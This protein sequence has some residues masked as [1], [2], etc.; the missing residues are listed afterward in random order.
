MTRTITTALSLLGAITLVGLSTAIGAEELWVIK[1]GVLNKEALT[2]EATKVTETHVGCGGET[3][4][5]LYVVTP[6]V[7]G[8]Q[9]L[10]RFMTAKSALGDCEFKVVFSASGGGQMRHLA[11]PYISI[12]DR[13]RLC[14]WKTGSP[15][16]LSSARTARPLKGFHAPVE[17]NGFDGNLQSMAV[18]RIG[19]KISCY[20]EGKK[21]NEQPIDPDVNLY[22]WFDAL[23]VSC[24][25]KSIKLTAEK[26]SDHLKTQFKS[27]GPITL[28]FDGT[29]RNLPKPGYGKATRYRLPSLA[30]SKKGTILAFGEARRVTG[31]DI[32]DIDAVVKRSE[33][34]GKTWSPEIVIW[35]AQ[36]L[37]V[38]N[39]TPVVDS[40]SGRIWVMMGRFGPGGTMPVNHFVSYSDDD[41]KTWS[42]PRDI[43]LRTKSPAGTDPTLPGPGGGIVLERGKHAGRFIV[44]IN[45]SNT[46]TCSPGV[47]YSD[48]R[49]ETWKVGGICRHGQL[50]VESSGVELFDGSLLFNGRTNARSGARVMSILPDG[51]TG[52]TKKYWDAEDLPRSNCQGSIVRYSW[53]KDGKPGLILF[54]GQGDPVGGGSIIGSYDD[55]KTW[56]WKGMFYEGPTVYRDI[57]VLGDGRVIAL[58]EKDGK[59]DLGFVVAPAPPA[60]PPATKP[61]E[62]LTANAEAKAAANAAAKAAK[63][64][65][66]VAVDADN[67]H[68]GLEAV[69]AM[70]GDPGTC[71]HSIWRGAVTTLPH[72]FV[73]DLGEPREIT[74]FTYQPR[75][76][77][78]GKSAIKDYEVYLSDRP[79]AKKPLAEG[80]PVAKGTFAKNQGENVV[81]FKASVK[82]R[83]FRL[84]A[85]SNIDGD[86]TW[87]G[88][89]ELTLHCKGVKFRAK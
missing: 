37:S 53:P 29:A 71:W 2:P 41:G 26:F 82:G 18:K 86:P 34:D 1:D 79:E 51:G 50:A 27:A 20:Y 62:K 43:D 83:Y 30:V 52:D 77:P 44:P 42:K 48:D 54:S 11:F 40:K 65:V 9:N 17:K 63:R 73:V 64:V 13:G 75:I 60:E 67:E 68:P 24:K 56:T 23:S 12:T 88:I 8:V 28:L 4:D 69:K 3:V 55:G 70:D 45:Y 87:A 84:R 21:L 57:A 46:G 85:L 7:G 89:G 22:L 59:D 33:D 31:H 19:D 66:R 80:T 39:P 25:I 14:F 58:F 10:A 49:G 74:G 81:L 15:V 5:G 72:E 38:N 16:I 61:V 78:A 76:H 47:A 36:A 32:G 6:T 35:D